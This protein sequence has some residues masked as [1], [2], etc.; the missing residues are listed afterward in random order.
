MTTF[1][2]VHGT[3][4]KSADWPALREGLTHAVSATGEYPVFKEIKWTGKNRASARQDAAAAI[5]TLVKEIH[6]T[7]PDNKIFII[8]H[9][10][11]GSAIAY[12][13]KE[14]PKRS[15]IL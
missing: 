14:I 15:K 8:G 11:G 4:A 9:S 13:F 3:F 2:L 7:S 6:S 1:I 12:S 5:L 10:H